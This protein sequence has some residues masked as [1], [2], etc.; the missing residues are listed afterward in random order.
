MCESFGTGITQV[1][2]NVKHPCSVCCCCAIVTD[3]RVI[4]FMIACELSGLEFFAKQFSFLKKDSANGAL[5]ALC[6]LYACHKEFNF[7][8]WRIFSL[9]RKLHKHCVEAYCHLLPL[10]TLH[11]GAVHCQQLTKSLARLRS[12]KSQGTAV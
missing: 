9:R 10:S 12:C 1:V 4:H 8:E 3:H 5:C 6:T 2:G 7:V 11:C